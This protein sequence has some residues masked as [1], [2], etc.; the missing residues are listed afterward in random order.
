MAGER[1]AGSFAGMIATFPLAWFLLALPFVSAAIIAQ[2][3]SLRRLASEHSW[4]TWPVG[5]LGLAVLLAGLMGRIP[6]VYALPMTVLSGLLA[7]YS[8]F[9]SP[10]KDSGND[11]D[12]D[13][14]RWPPPP[15]EEPPPE[16]IGDGPDW[17]LFDRLRRQW[18]RP[19]VPDYR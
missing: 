19:G 3:P 10:R 17:E 7:G 5:L 8:V 9:W 14:G 15:P 2:V 11:E 4:I 12:D 6:T 18:E 13:D 1:P 16:P